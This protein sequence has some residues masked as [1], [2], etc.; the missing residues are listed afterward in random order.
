MLGPLGRPGDGLAERLH[1]G[2][3]GGGALA[4]E[5]VDEAAPPARALVDQ[6][7]EL[8]GRGEEP[9]GVGGDRADRERRLGPEGPVAELERDD[10]EE[11]ADLGLLQEV[12]RRHQQGVGAEVEELRFAAEEAGAEVLRQLHEARLHVHAHVDAAP[13]EEVGRERVRL[14]GEEAPELAVEVAEPLEELADRDAREVVAE[15]E[16]RAHALEAMVLEAELVEPHRDRDRDRSSQSP[17][18]RP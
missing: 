13:P 17:A 15:N 1:G 5:G 14:L 7:V 10:P 16:L 11:L 6:R 9:G 12:E 3:T 4:I 8:A 2:V 18:C